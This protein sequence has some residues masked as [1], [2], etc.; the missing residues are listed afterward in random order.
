MSTPATSNVLELL[1]WKR[2]VFELYGEIRAEADAVRA[3]RRWRD[4]R[5]D[6]FASHPQSPLSEPDRESFRGV[7]YF[8][9]DAAARVVAP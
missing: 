1:D 4:V 6:L 8:D 2:R 7:Q 3:W 9:Y 5:D